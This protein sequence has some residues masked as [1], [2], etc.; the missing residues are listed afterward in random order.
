MVIYGLG[1]GVDVY[2]KEFDCSLDGQSCR[3][4]LCFFKTVT[5]V[6]VYTLELL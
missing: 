6:N 1:C 3:V 5:N 2:S 4:W